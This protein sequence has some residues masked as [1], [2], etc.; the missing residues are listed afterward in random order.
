V[1]GIGSTRGVPDVAADSSG[2]TGMALAFSTSG[3]SYW[4]VGAGGTSAGA[5]FWAGLIALA[6]Q[7]AGRSLGFVNPVIYRIARGPLYHRAFHDIT[8]GDN[9][10]ILTTASGPVTITGYQAGS[11]WD[12]V[13]GWG[14]PDASVLVPLLAR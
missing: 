13:T 5:S 11:G 10:V 7:K 12:P 6:D 9:T 1:P 3:A 8:T 2:I 4:L 14:T